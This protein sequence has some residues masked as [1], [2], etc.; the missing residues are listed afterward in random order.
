MHI[1]EALI[2]KHAQH[3]V[4]CIPSLH[5]IHFSQFRACLGIFQHGHSA[6]RGGT[7]EY[8]P[9]RRRWN[10]E[11]MHRHMNDNAA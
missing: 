2:Y 1:V 9:L 11:T 7:A 4:A 6:E 8:N 3:A 10:I 5:P